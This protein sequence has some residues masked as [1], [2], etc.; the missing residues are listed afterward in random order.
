MT[1]TAAE[2]LSVLSR[3]PMAIGD[4]GLAVCAARG[5]DLGSAEQPVG[6]RLAAEGISLSA[7][8]KL[9][10]SLV[11]GAQVVEVRGKHLWDLG[12]PTEGTK[13]GGRYFLLPQDPT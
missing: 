10:D 9:M 4:I 1:V 7:L 12:L 2:V 5:S 6:Q 8:Q 3:H 13:A 11:N